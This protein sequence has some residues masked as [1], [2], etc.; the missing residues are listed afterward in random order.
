VTSKLE[1]EREAKWLATFL[2]YKPRRGDRVIVTVVRTNEE[3]QTVE[4]GV[5]TVCGVRTSDVAAK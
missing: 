4:V 2:A 5:A 3:R 1:V